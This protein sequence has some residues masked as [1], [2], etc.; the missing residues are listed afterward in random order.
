MHGVKDAATGAV[1]TR[2][3]MGV[4]YVPLTQREKQDP[5]GVAAA[6]SPGGQP[7]QSTRGR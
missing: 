5:G 4:M 2:E 6:A 7:A 1:R 3:L